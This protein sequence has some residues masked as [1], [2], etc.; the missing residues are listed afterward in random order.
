MLS[1]K[2]DPRARFSRFCSSF[3][4]RDPGTEEEWLESIAAVVGK[5]D[6]NVI[7]PVFEQGTRFMCRW[8]ARLSAMAAIPLLPEVGVFDLV[9]DKGSLA[10]FLDEHDLPR[11]RTVPLSQAL[12]SGFRDLQFPLLIKPRQLNDGL[13]IQPF[14]DRDKLHD[15][16]ASHPD[17]RDDY[18]VQEFIEGDDLSCSVLCRDGEVLAHTIH[19]NIGSHERRFASSLCIKLVK[20]SH[21]LRTVTKVISALEW[22]GIANID[23]KYNRRK[24]R[25]EILEINPRYWGNLMGALAAG[26]NFPHLACLAAVN[27]PLPKS[28]YRVQNYMEVRD[29]AKWIAGKLTGRGGAFPNLLRETNL[30]YIL[31]D[32]LPF[33]KRSIKRHQLPVVSK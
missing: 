19:Q 29:A 18:I 15:F 12:Q 20:S 22:S 32:P 24:E 14:E 30:P 27:A 5:T 28:Q 3:H 33:L 16:A 25:A 21:T 17:P 8:R 2:P 1:S 23:F 4:R 26:V 31:R 7:L 6:T 9:N 11:P 13:G 10:Q